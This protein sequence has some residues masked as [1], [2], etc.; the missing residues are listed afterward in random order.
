MSINLDLFKTGTTQQRTFILLLD[1]DLPGTADALIGLHVEGCLITL[2]D[3]T[4]IAQDVCRQTCLRVVPMQDSLE[5]YPGE[6]ILIDRKRGGL[7]IIQLG[8]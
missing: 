1:T 6:P 3:P 7:D 4:D 8:L 2:A 5:R